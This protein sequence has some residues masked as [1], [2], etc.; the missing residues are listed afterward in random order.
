MM[1][2]PMSQRTIVNRMSEERLAQA[3][4][5]HLLQAVREDRADY[6]ARSRV[7]RPS[8]GRVLA[9]AVGSALESVRHGTTHR[10]HPGIHGAATR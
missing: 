2:D 7:A 9:T 8:L 1:P 3:R 4:R 6:E 5:D 10:T